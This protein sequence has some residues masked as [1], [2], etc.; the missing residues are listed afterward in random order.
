MK[1]MVHCD[2][3]RCVEVEEVEEESD[4]AHHNDAWRQK[5]RLSVYGLKGSFIFQ[6]LA[7]TQ[8]SKYPRGSIVSSGNW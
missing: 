1:V 5:D 3:D 6:H 4:H 2:D 7:A 8:A